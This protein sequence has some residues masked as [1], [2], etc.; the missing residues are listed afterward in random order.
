MCARPIDAK[1]IDQDEAEALLA[2]LARFRRVALAVSGGP[3]SLAL[4]SLATAWCSTRATP[5]LSV[6]TVDHDLR[7][8]SREEAELV[9]RLAAAQG[10]RHTILTWQHNAVDARL[11][12]RARQARYDLMA[13]YC[14]A[15]DISALV[16]AHQLDD[17][18]ETF[19]MRLK[20]GSGLDGL[21]A[22]P[23]EG[24][25]AGITLLRPLLDVPKAR[26]VATAEDAGISFVTDPSNVDPR[27]E[28]G[29]VRDAAQALATLGLTPEAIGLSARRLRRAR[30]ALEA[31]TDSFLG[32]HGETSPAGFASIAL[33]ALFAAPE[34]IA[35]R[36]MLRL[37]A[38]VGGPA[39]PVRL[40][41]LEALLAALKAHPDK[42]HTLGRCRLVP[43]GGRLLFF[44]EMRKEGLP[45]RDLR[46]GERMLW[47]NRFRI[48]L[49]AG[50]GAPITVRALGDEG[51]QALKERQALPPLVPRLAART[52]PAC[53]RDGALLCLPDFDQERAGPTPSSRHEGGLDCQA[54]FLWGALQRRVG[55][56]L[57]R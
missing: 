12:A 17:Q 27:F 25:W 20:R 31:A 26:L 10:L 47:D 38:T 53:W 50:S 57:G 48:E 41:K 34:E 14:H 44:R 40:V 29:R 30:A 3:D 1:P 28:R 23:A 36:A 2:P 19:L 56:G 13:A 7:P 22:I 37:I 49:G 21:A 45:V 46:P 39:E 5:V 6:L 33:D 43:R 55:T 52:L 54:T 32:H 15:H 35:L 8:D 16:T 4:M 24:I 11:Q 42:A 9:G 18:A 51:L